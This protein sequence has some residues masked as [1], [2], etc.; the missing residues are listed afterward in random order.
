MDS[1]YSSFDEQS[2]SH[3]DEV[4]RAN[5]G[6]DPRGLATAWAQSIVEDDT[7]TREQDKQFMLAALLE[8]ALMEEPVKT[9]A[10]AI[11]EHAT[12]YAV[13]LKGY[14][15]LLSI[16]HWYNVFLGK[17][18]DHMLEAVNDVFVQLADADIIM[19]IR[20][21]RSVASHT[22][23]AHGPL[24]EHPSFGLETRA[25]AADW[26]TG[27]LKLQ[28]TS[29]REQD[30]PYVVAALTE[31]A[32]MEQPLKALSVAI[33]EHT[34]DY[35]IAIKGHKSLQSVRHLFSTFLSKNRNHMLDNVTDIFVQLT[36]AGAVIVIHV[37]K[38]KFQTPS[39]NASSRSASRARRASVSIA[40]TSTTP[41]A[42]RR[43]RK[44]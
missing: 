39:L 30:R 32:L 37:K 8:A 34:T 3:A 31:A 25:A 13:T 2:S 24:H 26:A 20:L 36:D 11:N 14:K 22:S 18:R 7:V 5:A 17:T 29:T 10:A 4:A 1:S 16:R 33:N 38:V 42:G 44:Q 23:A 21:K 35:A 43:I 9:L 15:S 41:S 40:D 6:I 27:M 19:V 28:Q 12:D